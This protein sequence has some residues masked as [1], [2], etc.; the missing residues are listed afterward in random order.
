[1]SLMSATMLEAIHVPLLFIVVLRAAV[2]WCRTAALRAFTETQ[3]SS[4]SS[5][6]LR[7]AL[8]CARHGE[9]LCFNDHRVHVY[10]ASLT[11]CLFFDRGGV[12]APWR[13]VLQQSS[14]DM[15]ANAL[16]KTFGSAISSSR[17]AS[18]P[19]RDKVDA[20]CLLPP[21]PATCSRC[22]FDTRAHAAGV[23]F[24]SVK[25]LREH[26]V[27]YICSSRRVPAIS[28]TYA[29]KYVYYGSRY[30]NSIHMRYIYGAEVQNPQ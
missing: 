22:L 17:A 3:D 19:S 2:L 9:C 13:P 30:V 8:F 15:R 25:M 14:R 6:C 23:P 28:A 20:R 18:R 4:E 21:F 10:A 16:F 27:R 1:M 7:R 26:R 11:R 29:D 12:H 24:A 5:I